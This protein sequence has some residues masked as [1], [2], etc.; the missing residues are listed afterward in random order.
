M[1]NQPASGLIDARKCLLIALL[2]GALGLALFSPAIRYGFVNYD[3]DAYVYRNPNVL[4]GLS[5]SGVRYALTT[6]DIGTW[7]PLTW[8]SYEFDTSLQGPRASSYHT[9]NVLLHAAAGALLFLGLYLMR[10]SLWLSLTV[11][12]IFVVHPLRT[13]SVVWVA[14]R[15]DVLCAFFWALGLVAYGAYAR[16]RT[17]LRWTAVFLCFLAGLM[18]KMMMVTFP[19]VLLLL[20]FWP[21][22]RLTFGDQAA[23]ARARAL[24]LEK[25]PFFVATVLAVVVSATALH[26]RSAFRPHPTDGF[27]IFSGVAQNYLFYIQKILWPT[28]LSV[29]YPVLPGQWTTAA[30]SFALLAA[31]TAAVLWSIRRMPWLTV[32]WLWFV[33]TLVPVVGFVPFGDFVVAD[34]YAY[35]AS[36]G[37]SWAVLAWVER[38]TGRTVFGRWF[39]SAALVIACFSITRAD[40]PR[41]QD[42]LSLYDAALKIGPHYVAYSNRG[43][44]LLEKGEINAALADFNAAIQLN[45]AF[46]RAY[47]NR[48][49]ILSDQGRFDEAMHDFDA[50]LTNDPFFADAYDN[51]A[52]VFARTGQAEKSLIDYT[53]GIKLDP[54]NSLYYNNRAAAYFQL[55]RLSEAQ[56]DLDRCQQLGGQPHPGLVHALAEA[57]KPN[58]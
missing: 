26:D 6:C 48:G 38:L 14:E 23:R 39:A 49:S 31:I 16:K 54:G 20:D 3:D 8:L 12:A 34:R 28:R 11:A 19:F 53:R 43:V 33:G 7:A 32:G 37:L 2:V 46:A 24:L 27:N 21:L 4:Q 57:T 36:I 45:P 29:L 17:P 41:W 42:S 44:A 10:Q 58:P 15:K 55:R 5:V 30:M 22:Q 52:N 40:L 9:T 56:A 35:L 47:N 50:A 13:E 18:S 1:T 51:R 25:L